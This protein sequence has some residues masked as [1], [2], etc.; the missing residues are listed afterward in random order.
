LITKDT[1]NGYGWISI[2]LHWLTAVIVIVMLTTGSLTEAQQQ[3]NL[4]MVHLHTAVG[5]TAYVLLWAR[6]IW[7][8][9]VGHPG[10]LPRQGAYFL[11]IGK[12]FHLLLLASLAT[13]L[14]SGPL[15]EW[16]RGDAIEIF[17]LAIP[18]PA[19]PQWQNLLREVHHYV[20]LFISAGVALHML[21]ALKHAVV[22]A[23]GSLDR[24]LIASDGQNPFS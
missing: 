5:M 12:Y 13:M 19:F 22:D 17:H 3:T 11:V 24:I 2:I 6:I 1:E 4:S 21:A 9:V 7:R 18:G 16:S 20:A 15:I 8:F 10:P 23:D 14:L